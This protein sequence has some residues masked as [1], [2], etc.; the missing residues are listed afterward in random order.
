LAHLRPVLH[1]QKDTRFV[2]QYLLSLGALMTAVAAFAVP[3]YA[4][5]PAVAEQVAQ[6]KATPSPAPTPTPTPTPAPAAFQPST[7]L[8]VGVTSANFSGPKNLLN[9]RVFDNVSGVP[10]INDWNVTLAY[11]APL[12][13]KLELNTGT[14][15][16]VIHSWPQSLYICTNGIAAPGCTA[17]YNIQT[18]I[19]QAYASFSF[20]KFT[21]I[22][23]KFETL[24]GAELIESP[25]DLNFSRSIL[26]GFAVPFTHTGARV[27]FAATPTLNIVAGVNRGWDT[28][29][30]ESLTTL[31]NL[32]YP[33]N[34]PGDTSALTAEFGLAFNPSSTWGATLQGYSGKQENWLVSGCQTSTNCTRSLI[35]FVG[36]YHVNSTLTAIVN[37]DSGQQTNTFSP[38]FVSGTGTV[39]WKGIAGYL[40]EAF[41]P[42]FTGTIRYESFN[43]AQGFRTGVGV[44]TSWNEGTATVQYAANSH[45]TLRGEY[46]VDTATT[47]IF[48]SAKTPGGAVKALNSVGLEAIVHVP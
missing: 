28:T 16:N 37:V 30:P 42:A 45:L 10:Q 1:V 12:G 6:V 14:D 21:V 27:T 25:S 29:H 8:D 47:P 9:T 32:G 4:D 18:D 11:N 2:K 26:F 17:P 34:T 33:P 19:T 13:G 31:Q 15:A 23:G 36:T 44:G 40:S 39:T 20:G 7:Y 3:A 46:R 22:G 5:Q 38:A 24:A 48:A 41:S 43:D 35:D